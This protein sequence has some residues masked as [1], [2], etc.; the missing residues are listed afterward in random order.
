VEEAQ[1]AIDSA[2][3]EA[4]SAENYMAVEAQRSQSRGHQRV[5]CSHKLCFREGVLVAVTQNMQTLDKYH[6]S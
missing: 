3:V 6:T 2:H 1:R 4:C 5:S